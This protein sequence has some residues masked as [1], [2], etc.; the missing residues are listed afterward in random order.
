MRFT[1][2]KNFLLNASLI[3]C[4]LGIGQISIADV[5]ADNPAKGA[6]TT[7]RNYMN[8]PFVRPAQVTSL[9]M[10]ETWPIFYN[11]GPLD[12][13]PKD[14]SSKILTMGTGL[15]SANTFSSSA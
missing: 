2:N 11:R 1:F 15:P 10:P 8:D 4:L 3:F 7:E 9:V 12:R 5:Y 13:S 6:E 14:K